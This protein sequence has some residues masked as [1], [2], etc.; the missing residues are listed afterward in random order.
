MNTKKYLALL[1][2]L[3]VSVSCGKKEPDIT[4]SDDNTQNVTIQW[5]V[6]NKKN[7]TPTVS[8]LTQES[9][10][11]L[12]EEYSTLSQ[13][14]KNIQTMIPEKLD[15]MKE[16][17]QNSLDDAET[18]IDTKNAETLLELIAE[19]KTSRDSAEI[20][21]NISISLYE[22]LAPLHHEVNK[23]TKTFIELLNTNIEQVADVLSEEELKK[24]VDLNTYTHNILPENLQNMLSGLTPEVQE[25][26]QQEVKN[27]LE[28]WQKEL[29]KAK[30]DAN[31]EIEQAQEEVKKWLEK[32][33]A[34]IKVSDEIW[35]IP[36]EILE[37]FKEINLE[38]E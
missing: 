15:T 32:I 17:I 30:K 5:D 12:V 21:G 28:E 24:F 19:A 11:Q 7:T 25:F 1:A 26:V 14:W 10:E 33:P 2:I 13:G 34:E 8:V 23:T 29:Q 3:A 22:E 20:F 31:E 18:S 36:D 4:I 16:I 6:I 35:G 27:G 37:L 38:L 9:A